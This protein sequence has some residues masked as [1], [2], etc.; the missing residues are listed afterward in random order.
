MEFTEPV[1]KEV[2]EVSDNNK[3]AGRET[4]DSYDWSGGC[5]NG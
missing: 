5:Y 4:C 3:N 2:V 1:I